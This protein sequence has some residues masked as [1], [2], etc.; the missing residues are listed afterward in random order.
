MFP[1]SKC[2]YYSYH[3]IRTY[4]IIPVQSILLLPALAAM[5]AT[6]TSKYC[7]Y[8]ISCNNDN[9]NPVL[10]LLMVHV[11]LFCWKYTF[12]CFHWRYLFLFYAGRWTQGCHIIPPLYGIFAFRV[13]LFFV[14]FRLETIASIKNNRIFIFISLLRYRYISFFQKR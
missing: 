6:T 7:Y 11:F 8:C 3:I 12:F 9:N 10:L 1:I 14:T 13:V 4:I 2:W 5:A